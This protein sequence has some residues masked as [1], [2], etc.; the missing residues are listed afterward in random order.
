MSQADPHR[1]PLANHWR[2]DPSIT[3]LNHGSFGACPL[4]VLE[5]QS[6]LR[7]RLEHEPV[8]FLVEDLE[9]LQDEAR[10][11]LA[12]FIGAQP[13]D[14]ALITNATEGV[15][16]VLRSLDFS[17]GDELLTTNHEYNACRNALDFIAQ[18]TGA[19]VT[20]ANIPFPIASP[21]Q[22]LT[23]IADA[24]SPR[25]RLALISHVTSPTALIFPIQRI[26][27]LLAEC[28][29]PTLVDGAHAPGMLTLDLAAINAAYYTGN[30][31]KWLCAPKGAGF[32]W[33]RSDLQHNIRPL[34]IS[35]GANSTRTDRSR[36]QIEFGWTG[37]NDPTA[38]LCIP[39]ALRFM[40]SLLPGGWTDIMRTNRAL[41]LR[42]RSILCKALNTDPPAPDDMIGAIASLPLPDAPAAPPA[43]SLDHDPLQHTLLNE[44]AIQV[45]IVPWPAHP[46]RLIRISA[47]LYNT[48]HQYEQL[49]DALRTRGLAPAPHHRTNS[50]TL[51]PS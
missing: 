27:A 38:A 6:E 11:A 10:A 2:L 37:T 30:C 14:L 23:A 15:N 13:D 20:I 33:V 28:N 3:F 43:P 35:H 26:V 19:V 31:H 4:P 24:A 25:T 41:A 22:A 50:P 29:I 49:A 44:H 5:T 12:A 40:H 16:A 46:K 48:P 17:P 51:L 34:S 36:F 47:Q 42:A 45:P 39:A 21:D 32:L 7:A 8:R 18:R 1:S 9:S